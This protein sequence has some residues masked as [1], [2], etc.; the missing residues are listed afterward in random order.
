M[1]AYL[2]KT[3][4]FTFVYSNIYQLY[5]KAKNSELP[6][7]VE[8]AATGRVI[9]DND[10]QARVQD[11]KA[12]ELKAKE[13][14]RNFPLPMGVREAEEK[15]LQQKVKSMTELKQNLEGLTEARDKLRFLLEEL[16]TLTDKKK[17]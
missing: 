8:K 9:K 14:A 6:V 17:N 13:G 7:A 2:D 10:F 4:G 1:S 5:Q 15:A 12:R 16:E 11:Y 3:Q